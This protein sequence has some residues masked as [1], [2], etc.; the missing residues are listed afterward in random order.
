M[1][2]LLWVHEHIHLLMQTIHCHLSAGLRA[3]GFNVLISFFGA[4]FVNLTLSAVTSKVP[5]QE[6]RSRTFLRKS[7]FSFLLVVYSLLILVH[8]M[9]YCQKAKGS[10]LSFP[11][12]LE[13]L[14]R[15]RHG[16][17]S[18]VYDE[19]GRCVSCIFI[20]LS[21][22]WSLRCFLGVEELWHVCISVI[23]DFDWTLQWSEILIGL[24]RFQPQVF[25][26]LFNTYGKT[27]P[28][29]LMLRE[30]D[31]MRASFHRD[32]SLLGK[33]E[34]SVV[35]PNDMCSNVFYYDFWTL[36]FSWK[37]VSDTK[38]Y[39]YFCKISLFAKS[40]IQ[41][42]HACLS[43]FCYDFLTFSFFPWGNR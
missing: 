21:D 16:N 5:K 22:A 38:Y 15:G 11:I 40:V 27:Y 13:N 41:H 8:V 4:V 31:E 37:R 10:S 26:N 34:K 17:D 25:E 36:F 30:L 12:H 24:C 20:M 19:D 33:Y 43:V 7:C 6:K 9:C 28:D 39:Y 18:G 1:Q 3:I 23:R 32:S 14:H 2:N 42:N 35:W 29:R